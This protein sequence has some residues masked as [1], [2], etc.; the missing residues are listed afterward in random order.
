MSSY[1]PRLRQFAPERRGDR[2]FRHCHGVAHFKGRTRTHDH[3]GHGR[4]AI[5]KLESRSAQWNLMPGA[6]GVELVGPFKDGRRSRTVV[7]TG[8]FRG[9][10]K[11]PTVEHP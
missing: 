5:R 6:N 8:A 1:K 11:D 7:I 10:S 9:I 4:V 2:P 3:G